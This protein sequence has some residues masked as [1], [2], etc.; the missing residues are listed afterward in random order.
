MRRGCA[1]RVECGTGSTGAAA[2]A[3]F[4]CRQDDRGYVCAVGGFNLQVLRVR[5][6]FLH[7]KLLVAEFHSFEVGV[8]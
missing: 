2:P 7:R 3:E 8:A 5:P 6:V 1:L 4:L